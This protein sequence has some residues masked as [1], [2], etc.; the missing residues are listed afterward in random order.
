M[1]F[2]AVVGF[3]IPD[4]ENSVV[5]DYVAGKLAALVFVSVKFD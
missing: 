3:G 2:N 1:N 4:A 5:F